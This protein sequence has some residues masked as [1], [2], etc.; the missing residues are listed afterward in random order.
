LVNSVNNPTEKLEAAA[1]VALTRGS[2]RVQVFEL[3]GRRYVVKRLAQQERSRLQI[4]FM[5][6]LVRWL[7]GRSLPS[8]TLSLQ[9]GAGALDYEATRLRQLAAAGVRVPQVMLVTPEFFILEYCGTVVADEME[10][11]PAATSRLV[12]LRLAR[13]LGEFHRAGQWHGGAQIKNITL[14]DDVSYRI[15]CEENFG[16]FLPLPATQAAD[17]IVFLNSISLVGQLDEAESRQLLPQLLTA[18]FSV[19][20][21]EEIRRIIRR[22]MP[23]M[24]LFAAL[25]RPFQRF[26]RKGIRR[27]LILVDILGAV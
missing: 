21:D 5:R 19:H 17:L 9:Q 18:Y 2:G 20:P 25:I 3:D 16:D 27:I 15:D 8:A 6:W 7:T 22:A 11:W 1:R 12:L 4:F 10:K 26:S 23:L 14:Q 13:E 24:R